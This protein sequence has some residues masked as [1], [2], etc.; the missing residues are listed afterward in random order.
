MGPELAEN[1]RD[2]RVVVDSSICNVDS[3]CDSG[4]KGELYA[5]EGLETKLS[6]L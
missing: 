6:A 3:V 5:G 4:E 1:K 2:H